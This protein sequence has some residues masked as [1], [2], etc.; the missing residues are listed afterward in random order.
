MSPTPT[1]L[2]LLGR[3]YRGHILSLTRIHASTVSPALPFLLYPPTRTSLPLQSPH[4]QVHRIHRFEG[5]QTVG[6]LRLPALLFCLLTTRATASGFVE[7]GWS[8]TILHVPHD[9][10]CSP[11]SVSSLH[12]LATPSQSYSLFHSFTSLH[13]TYMLYTYGVCLFFAS[14]LTHPTTTHPEHHRHLH[15]Y[16]LLHSPRSG[17]RWRRSTTPRAASTGLTRPPTGGSAARATA[18]GRTWYAQTRRRATIAL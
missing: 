13:C 1:P 7:V 11:D 14:R 16:H 6:M 10:F 2:H 18:S 4:D 17:S 3:H 5:S 8:H 15:H 9:M 12:T